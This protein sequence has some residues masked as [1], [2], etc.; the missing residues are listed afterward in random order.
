M[1]QERCTRWKKRHRFIRS[2]F[3]QLDI[4]PFIQQTMDMHHYHLKRLCWA[5]LSNGI[6][7]R[8]SWLFLFRSSAKRARSRF[9][10]L[11]LESP[12][13]YER[14]LTHI[15][16]RISDIRRDAET[17]NTVNVMQISVDYVH[18]RTTF[19]PLPQWSGIE[20]FFSQNWLF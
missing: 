16:L 14:H 7:N 8:L 3:F 9:R 2:A 10:S 11:P 20:L 4:K 19:D 17:C 15:E 12:P 13:T 18:D 1:N 6:D 5:V